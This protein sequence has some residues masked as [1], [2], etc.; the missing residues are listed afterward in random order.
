MLSMDRYYK[1]PKRPGCIRNIQ[2]E[3]RSGHN[4]LSVSIKELTVLYSSYMSFLINGGLFIPTIEKYDIGDEVF[5]LLKLLDEKK[6]IPLITKVVW[7]TPLQAQANRVAGI[8]L[9][10]LEKD[11]EAKNKIEK[12]LNGMLNSNLRTFTL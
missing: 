1:G 3:K 10:F 6:L 2:P 12:C 9:R 7:I 11:N 4:V 5:L 8:G